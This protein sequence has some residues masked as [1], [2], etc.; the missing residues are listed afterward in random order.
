MTEAA[1]WPGCGTGPRFAVCMHLAS[2]HWSCGGHPPP[3]MKDPSA[4]PQVLSPG[5]SWLQ[6][7]GQRGAPG[8]LTWC[9]P[10]PGS[11]PSA[12]SN[13]PGPGS[14][15]LALLPPREPRGLLPT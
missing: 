2:C 12:A 9:P 6:P 15:G 4:L 13:T 1:P 7:Q 11:Q 10:W 14:R 5:V 8:L 3:N